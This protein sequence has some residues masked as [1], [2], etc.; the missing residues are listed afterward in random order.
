SEWNSTSIINHDETEASSLV[1]GKTFLTWESCELF[2][3]EWA[4]RQ[5]FNI[6]KDG[7]KFIDAMMADIKFMTECC[8]F[9]ATIQRK[10]L[11]GKYPVQPIYLKDLYTA[12]QKYYPNNE[13]LSNDASQEY[14]IAQ[15]YLEFL[16]KSKCYWAH[17]F[18]EFKFTGGMIASSRVESVNA[19]LKRLLH[20]SNIS[21]CELI[22][23]INRLLDIQDKENE[24]RF[25]RL[26]ITN[27]KNQDKANFL[28]TQVDKCLQKFLTSTIL[29]MQHNEINQ[30]VYYILNII[31]IDTA[32]HFDEVRLRHGIRVKD[33]QLINNQ[34][35][36]D[37]DNSRV[38]FKQLLDFVKLHNI[39][40]IWAI[41]VG[42]SLKTKHSTSNAKFHIQMLPSRWYHT[43][44][45]RDKEPFLIDD[46]FF[47][48][49]T[50]ELSNTP[51]L[52]LYLFRQNDYDFREDN[53]TTLGQ[54]IT[55]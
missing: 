47:H 50:T 7:K 29:Q 46:K 21:L 37:I 39:Y 10:F 16:Y 48:D 3:N 9:R 43:K 20:N 52:C 35:E 17:Y 30:S 49:L 28:F 34:E 36:I 24:Y 6:I 8:K 19:C 2:L 33:D 13:T 31:T 25:W 53:L 15:N 38:S 12:I 1:S 55:Y 42:N 11:Q 22:I 40:Q 51:I 14:P 26:A 5:G 41:K 54:K 45:N 18:T 32:E 27:I 23:E 44:E 4:K